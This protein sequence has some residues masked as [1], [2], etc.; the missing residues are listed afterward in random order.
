MHSNNFLPYTQIGNEIPLQLTQRSLTGRCKQLD[1]S[2][3]P[4]DSKPAKLKHT[5]KTWLGEMDKNGM[6]YRKETSAEGSVCSGCSCQRGETVNP[7][8]EQCKCSRACG[9][10][11]AERQRGK[12]Y[13]SIFSVFYF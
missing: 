9:Q 10:N 13:F 11:E 4:P 3:K 6:L 8:N 1:L 2:P 7:S 12:T 5:G